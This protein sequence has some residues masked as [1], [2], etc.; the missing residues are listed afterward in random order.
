MPLNVGCVLQEIRVAKSIS[1][2]KF[3]TG[4]RINATHCACGDII[5]TFET[6]GI[7]QT[8]SSLERWFLYTACILRCSSVLCTV[9]SFHRRCVFS[10][11]LMCVR[12]VRYMNV[13]LVR[14]LASCN[15][16][17]ECLS[18]TDRH[19]SCRINVLFSFLSIAF[20]AAAKTDQ[21]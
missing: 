7:G 1:G 12:V 8:P 10:Y 18:C 4:S 2:D 9:N 5:V 3:V 11:R 15:R 14:A 17:C 13:F 21:R 19:T 20:V 6:D 16:F